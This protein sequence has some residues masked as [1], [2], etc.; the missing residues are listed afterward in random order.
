MEIN[1]GS[2]QYMTQRFLSL[3]SYK[4]KKKSLTCGWVDMSKNVYWNIICETTES[5]LYESINFCHTAVSSMTRDARKS[6]IFVI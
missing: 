1:P 2:I 4:G 3:L 6:W 5:I